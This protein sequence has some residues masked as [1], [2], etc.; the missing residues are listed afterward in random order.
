MNV[1]VCVSV[2]SLAPCF[3]SISL[4]QCLCLMCSLKCPSVKCLFASSR[5]ELL[6]RLCRGFHS[7]SGLQAAQQEVEK[8]WTVEDK[9]WRGVVGEEEV[10]YK[11]VVTLQQK[12][13]VS[14]VVL[15]HPP[16]YMFVC[17]CSLLLA[18]WRTSEESPWGR[19]TSWTLHFA[20]VSTA[21]S[22]GVRKSAAYH[23]WWGTGA[24]TPGVWHSAQSPSS[25]CGHILSLA[26]PWAQ[27][28]T[29]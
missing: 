17:V 16:L 26:P 6:W 21:R 20:P 2:S 18:S 12:S 3:L 22:P 8:G 5:W 27:P 9:G 11:I 1:C 15:E 10:N 19:T 23:E 28:L 25:E 4:C 7:R 24:W 14:Y 13:L 29:Q